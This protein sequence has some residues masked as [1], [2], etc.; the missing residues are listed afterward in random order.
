[1]KI[2]ES[3]RDEGLRGFLLLPTNINE[4]TSPVLPAKIP[5]Y[6]QD[7]DYHM[8]CISYEGNIDLK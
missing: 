7:Y 5:E 6:F 4:L 3:G 8:F 2:Y 1:M